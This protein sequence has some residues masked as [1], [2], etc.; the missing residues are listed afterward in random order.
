MSYSAVN[1]GLT[2][3]SASTASS[4]RTRASI[5]SASF[6]D[7]SVSKKASPRQS[8]SKKS[9][10]TSKKNVIAI[11]IP[12]PRVIAPAPSR[13]RSSSRATTF[14][15]VTNFTVAE[16]AQLSPK[17]KRNTSEDEDDEDED[18]EPSPK[19]LRR[20]LPV[21]HLERKM[22][23]VFDW[24]N[25][26]RPESV[27]AIDWEGETTTPQLDV[28]HYQSAEHSAMDV[29]F[30]KSKGEHWSRII[31]SSFPLLTLPSP[32]L[33]SPSGNFPLPPPFPFLPSLLKNDS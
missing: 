17:R 26:V 31:T 7:V 9:Q 3:T 25:S 29:N 4:F 13:A 6:K 15:K 14:P 27:D 2:Q 10:A 22:N 32:E 23:S 30:S 5:S 8:T 1:G 21:G 24:K 20:T 12:K 18:E 11:N 28:V 33:L 16:V 19:R